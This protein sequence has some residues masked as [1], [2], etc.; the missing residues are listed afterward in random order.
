M[1]SANFYGFYNSDSLFSDSLLNIG[2]YANN[3]FLTITPEQ[4]FADLEK[5]TELFHKLNDLTDM[6]E[7]LKNISHSQNKVEE[8][9]NEISRLIDEYKEHANNILQSYSHNKRQRLIQ[10]SEEDSEEESDVELVVPKDEVIVISDDEPE[11]DIDNLKILKNLKEY[12]EK[13]IEMLNLLKKT[14]GNKK[15][16]FKALKNLMNNNNIFEDLV[17]DF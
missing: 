10:D 14:K 13:S 17:G 2:S 4:K 8:I 7:G 15:M 16:I 9:E 1:F 12:N 5:H 3:L 6:L 11:E